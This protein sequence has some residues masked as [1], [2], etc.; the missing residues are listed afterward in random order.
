MTRPFTD[1]ARYAKLRRQVGKV[2]FDV[3]EVWNWLCKCWYANVIRKGQDLPLTVRC[4]KKVHKIFDANFRFV[5][6]CSKLSL[7][8]KILF[9]FR[10]VRDIGN[11]AQRPTDC[12]NDV[13]ALCYGT[14]KRTGF[15]FRYELCDVVCHAQPRKVC[16]VDDWKTSWRKAFN[17]Q[18]RSKRPGCNISNVV[19]DSL[20]R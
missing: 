12:Y 10:V 20:S 17:F 3:L 6:G 16:A 14:R 1:N 13:A 11:L 5:K 18:V 2:H 7:G 9:V 8:A 15:C 4:V 19:A